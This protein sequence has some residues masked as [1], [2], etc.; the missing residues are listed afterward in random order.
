MSRGV[1]VAALVQARMGSTRLPG[2]MLLCLKGLPVVEWVARRVARARLVDRVVFAIPDTPAD[3]VLAAHLASCGAAVFRG[4]EADVLGRFCAAAA[5]AGA[6]TVVRVCADNPLVSPEAIDDLVRFHRETPC[7]LAYN[8]I[9]RGN[10]YPD[11]LGAEM[12]A[13]S[14]LA[15]LGAAVTDPRLREHVTL[16]LYEDPAADVR[17][18]DPPDPRLRHPEVRLD[19]DT[20]EDYRRLALMDIHPD[21]TGA[22]AVALFRRSA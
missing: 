8:H 3:D 6:E 22:E 15:R 2:K 1:R 17:T 9:P 12:L 7:D 5:W 11:G 20:F 4:D 13:A 18:F 19:I 21:M 16:A 10:L 14:T